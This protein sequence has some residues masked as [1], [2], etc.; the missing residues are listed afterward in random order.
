MS[1][2]DISITIVMKE[3]CTPNQE[4]VRNY[5]IF[6][7]FIYKIYRLTIALTSFYG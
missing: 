5:L 1:S 7:L 4:Q 3:L 6:K 2:T